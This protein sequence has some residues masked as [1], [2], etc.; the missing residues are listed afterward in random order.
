MFMAPLFLSYIPLLS[1]WL[2]LFLHILYIF[3]VHF[4]IYVS[5]EP[6][7]SLRLRPSFVYHSL[8]RGL[9]RC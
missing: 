5:H 3:N 1:P 7:C 9:Q 6:I 8:S 2:S 4:I